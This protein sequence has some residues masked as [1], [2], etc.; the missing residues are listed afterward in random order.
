MAKPCQLA[1][2][3]VTHVQP[4][5]LDGAGEV[6]LALQILDDTPV[7][8]RAERVR[9]GGETPIQKLLHFRHKPSLE[10]RFGAF[11]DATVQLGSRRVKRKDAQAARAFVWIGTLVFLVH[12]GAARLQVDLDCS[13]HSW[14][15]ARVKARRRFWIETPEES[16][17]MFRTVPVAD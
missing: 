9:A 8:M 3:V 5:L 15:V 16:M 4:G 14:P 2:R 1:F 17:K 12:D 13:L 11:V 7:T 6:A 10:M